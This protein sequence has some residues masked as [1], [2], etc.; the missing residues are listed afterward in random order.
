[1]TILALDY[2]KRRMGLAVSDELG[3]TAQGLPTLLRKNTRADLAALARLVQ[4]RSVDRILMG[5]PLHMSGDA[6]VQ[7]DAARQ[8]GGQLSRYTGKPVQSC[9]QRLTTAQASPVLRATG[10]TIEKIA[11]R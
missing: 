8:F 10:I 4:N 1:M 2:G 6:G 3:V 5:D 11:R 9:D 7:A